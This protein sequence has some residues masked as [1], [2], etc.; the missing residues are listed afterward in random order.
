[1]STRK[2][3]NSSKRIHN[4]QNQMKAHIQ[5][6]GTLARFWRYSFT[7]SFSVSNPDLKNRYLVGLF[8]LY[9]SSNSMDLTIVSLV[10]ITTR[11]AETIVRCYELVAAP[12]YTHTKRCHHASL[13]ARSFYVHDHKGAYA[14]MYATIYSIFIMNP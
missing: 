13:L 9:T 3:E 6:S 5:A 14:H 1:M 8:P 10:G 2:L 4:S 7:Q 11:R 12:S